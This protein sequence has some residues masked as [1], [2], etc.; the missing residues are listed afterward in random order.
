MPCV[1]RF[2][3]IVIYMYYNDHLP[4]HFHAEYAE[5][6]ATISIETLEILSGKLPNRARALVLE[7][8]SLHRAE[9]RDN[10]ERARQGLPLQKIDSLD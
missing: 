8:A 2:F 9:L 6:E 4:P 5:W 7:W 10:W 3:G 1:S